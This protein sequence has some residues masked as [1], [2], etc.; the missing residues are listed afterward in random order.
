MTAIVSGLP[1]HPNRRETS[2][3]P[4]QGQ[5]KTLASIISGGQS[6]IT[7]APPAFDAMREK[8]QIGRELE[9]P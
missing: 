6:G 1:R 8:A 9:G 5:G 2:S 7:I 4:A 3:P